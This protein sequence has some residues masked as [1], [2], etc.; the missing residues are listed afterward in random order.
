MHG[1]IYL[2]KDSGLAKTGLGPIDL[3][4]YVYTNKQMLGI[5]VWVG[6]SNPVSVQDHLTRKG[7]PSGSNNPERE[8]R[9]MY[10]IAGKGTV[11]G[12]GGFFQT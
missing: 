2:H 10:A 9:Y 7:P 1:P 3:V 12:Q 6:A 8:H 4:I 5:T 11:F